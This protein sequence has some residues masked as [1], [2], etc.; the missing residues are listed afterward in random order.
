MLKFGQNLPVISK[1]IFQLFGYIFGI[2]SNW[3]CR[4]SFFLHINCD[5]KKSLVLWKHNL[6]GK[7]KS[8]NI[9]NRVSK[10]C[11]YALNVVISKNNSFFNE[12][13]LD[14]NK[15][16]RK[17]FHFA[18]QKA[19]ME[20]FWDV[21]KCPWRKILNTRYSVCLRISK[22]VPLGEALHIL[23]PQFSS[24]LSFSTSNRSVIKTLP[25]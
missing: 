14:I 10:F 11:T 18:S 24:P 9:L 7:H 15:L 3:Q 1:I 12:Y 16:L 17:D 21:K 13:A 2:K 23:W 22:I 19:L 4:N 5:K 6:F 20:K 25:V 8:P